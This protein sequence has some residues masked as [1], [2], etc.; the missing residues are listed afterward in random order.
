M[1]GSM[2]NAFEKYKNELEGVDVLTESNRPEE[3]V[4]NDP[5]SS[6]ELP[7][8][9]IVFRVQI[10]TSE[11]PIRLTDPK[12]KGHT[13]FEYQQG[14]LYKYTVGR[15]INDY[16]AANKLK[17]Q[18]RLEG[19]KHAFVVGFLRGERIDL[20]KAINLAEK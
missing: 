9:D 6:D 16:D 19:F 7:S 10:E 1:A 15:H 20:Q 5:P 12:F 14:G 8:E 13:V 17:Q 3:V 18:M 2:F 11:N 4:N